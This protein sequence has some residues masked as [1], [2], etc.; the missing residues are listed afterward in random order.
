MRHAVESWRGLSRANE[1]P[2]GYASSRGE[3][4]LACQVAEGEVNRF[5]LGA[6]VVAV[7]DQLEIR[8][9]DLNVRRTFGIHVLDTNRVC[10]VQPTGQAKLVVPSAPCPA[11][12]SVQQP[13]VK[14][15]PVRCSTTVSRWLQS[16][17]TGYVLPPE[18]NVTS[19]V[20]TFAACPTIVTTGL[21]SPRTNSLAR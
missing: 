2:D 1:S 6:Q 3:H 4:G 16:S 15:S 21:V 8:V 7:H 5:R 18:E 17:S 12:G 19:P 9:L 20:P 10:R 11:R 13:S 14:C